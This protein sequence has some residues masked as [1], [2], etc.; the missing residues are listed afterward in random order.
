V[1]GVGTPA[2]GGVGAGDP[3][4]PPLHAERST[5]RGAVHVREIDIATE[6]VFDGPLV[7][8]RMQVGCVRFSYV[9][10]GSRTPRRYR[11]QP[12]LAES[13]ALDGAQAASPTPLTPVQQNAIRAEVRRRVRPDYTDTRYGQ[14]AYLQLALSVPGE[15]AAGAEDGAE[16][17]VYC[18]LKQPQRAANLQ[19]RLGEYLPFGLDAGLIRVT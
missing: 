17:G 8:D 4:G 2:V 14:P 1:D 13:A 16:M 10:A 15:I 12:D 18:H 7:A 6:V 5:L 19:V 9:N 3:P 11:C